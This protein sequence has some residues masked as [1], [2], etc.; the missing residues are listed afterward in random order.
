MESAEVYIDKILVSIRKIEDHD[1]LFK[2][3]IE[4]L[5]ENSIE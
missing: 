2:E 3:V 5:D 1:K 4:R